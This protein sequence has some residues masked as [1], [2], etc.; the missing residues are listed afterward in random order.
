MERIIAMLFAHLWHEKR[1][2]RSES[3]FYFYDDDVSTLRGDEAIEVIVRM[4]TPAD[5][6]E[7][8]EDE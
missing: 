6:L 8:Q 4:R 1:D 2:G 7:E 3:K 5:I